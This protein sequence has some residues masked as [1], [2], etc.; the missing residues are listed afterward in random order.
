MENRSIFFYIK[1]L[2]RIILI[3]GII[4]S[5]NCKVIKSG[6]KDSLMI[7]FAKLIYVQKE[8]KINSYYRNN[9]LTVIDKDN[10]EIKRFQIYAVDSLYRIVQ[11]QNENSLFI[12]LSSNGDAIF[13]FMGLITRLCLLEGIMEKTGGNWM[14][15]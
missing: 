2:N 12:G 9:T 8:N 6:N 15:V 5:C 7:K 11:S 10:I 13:Q 14:P 4:T 3:S 1:S